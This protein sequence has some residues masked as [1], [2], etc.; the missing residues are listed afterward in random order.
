VES[1]PENLPLDPFCR[2]NGISGRRTD[3]YLQS[4]LI[5]AKHVESQ[6]PGNEV[7]LRSAVAERL[8]ELLSGKRR[9]RPTGNHIIGDLDEGLHEI[10]PKDRHDV[11]WNRGNHHHG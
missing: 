4:A 3:E 11:R 10:S 7:A 5:E 9:R 8:K 6:L 2:H 1:S